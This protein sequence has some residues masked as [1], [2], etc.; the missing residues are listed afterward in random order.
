MRRTAQGAIG[1]GGAEP[2]EAD[3]SEAPDDMLFSGGKLNVMLL[4]GVEA[5]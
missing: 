5:E 1:R 2:S 3:L 4:S